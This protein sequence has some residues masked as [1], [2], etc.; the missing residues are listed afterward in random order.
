MGRSPEPTVNNFAAA[1]SEK[2]FSPNL[3]PAKVRAGRIAPRRT[4]SD[5]AKPARLQLRTPVGAAARP[6]TSERTAPCEGPD[7]STTRGQPTMH[8]QEGRISMRTYGE[9]KYY[10]GLDWGKRQHQVNI[11]D[12][13]GRVVARF[14]FEHSGSGWAQFRERIQ[15]YPELG[16]AIETS[17]GPAVEQ[18][19]RSGVTIYPV[20][21]KAAKSYRQ[22]QAPSGVKDDALDAWSLADALRLDGAKWRALREQDPILEELRL[23]CADE[24]ALI[25][26]RTALVNQLQ[27]ALQEYY[28]AALEAFDDWTQAY[29]WAFV[30]AF[31]TPQKLGQATGHRRKVFLHTHQLWRSD[32]APQRLAIFA[33]AEGFCGGESVTRAKSRLALALCESLQTLER[34]LEEYRAAIERLFGEHPD[35]DLFDSLPG[36]GPKLGPRLLSGVGSERAEYPQAQGLQ[37]MAGSAPVSYQ[38]GQMRV[39]KIRWHCDRFL[40]HTVHLWADTSRK[41]C[42]WAQTYYLAKRAQGKSHSCALRCLGQRWLKI[43]WKMW[44]THTPYDPEFHARNQQRHGSWVLQFQPAKA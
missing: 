13:S 17:A 4:R 28:P 34:Q 44:Q 29:T 6:P 25:E 19:L 43:L 10:G 15:A 16:M 7:T 24:A 18:L 12:G 31:P 41:T 36:I 11:L 35:H 38:S 26:Q 23:L 2:S 22:R 5:V 14:G 1:R 40:R 39:V 37:C 20:H 27:Q 33:R 30:K 32:T 8:K 42:A 3:R 21:P 9:L